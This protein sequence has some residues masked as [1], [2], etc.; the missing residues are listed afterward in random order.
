MK[1]K[2]IV[3]PFFLLFGV[4][5]LTTSCL[6][7]DDCTSESF[8]APS[9]FVLK[10]VDENGTNLITNDTY[11][12]DSI[13]LFYKDN[14]GNSIVSIGF[15]QTIDG[16]Y[17]VSSELPRTILETANDTY[18]LYLSLSDTDTLNI[19]IVQDTDGCN[20]WH[21]YDEYKYNGVDMEINDTGTVFI[22]VK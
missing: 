8:S 1:K 3:F 16:Y 6:D 21:H 20:V 9:S 19:V 13:T 10:L 22:G 17:I 7:S 15:Q 2:Q 5:F 12:P 11:H 18:F 14:M 4:L